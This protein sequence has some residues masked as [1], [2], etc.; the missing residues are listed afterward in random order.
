M[1][2]P[3]FVSY[4]EIDETKIKTMLTVATKISLDALKMADKYS[5]LVKLET[6]RDGEFIYFWRIFSDKKPISQRLWLENFTV[7]DDAMN[8]VFFFPVYK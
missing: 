4:Q 1:I 7:D 6:G 8:E 2:V 5:F 3:Y